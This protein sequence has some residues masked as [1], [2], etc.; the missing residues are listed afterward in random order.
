MAYR[1]ILLILGCF[2]FMVPAN[3]CVVVPTKMNVSWFRFRFAVFVRGVLLYGLV[4]R[5]SILLCL[6]IN[7]FQEIQND[8]D[9]IFLSE[10]RFED[11]FSFEKKW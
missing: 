3:E 1:V 9:A 6:S 8:F 10:L 7:C 11:T 2:E 4:S 5:S